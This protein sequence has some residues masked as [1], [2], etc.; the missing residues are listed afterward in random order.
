MTYGVIGLVV[1]TGYREN[2]VSCCAPAAQ[3]HYRAYGIIFKFMIMH[4]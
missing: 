1:E 3:L 2:G 4:I